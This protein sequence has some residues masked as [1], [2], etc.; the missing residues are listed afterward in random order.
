MSDFNILH[1]ETH[2]PCLLSREC[3]T[4]V[5]R[6]GNKAGLRPGRLGDLIRQNTGANA[7]GL[8]CH[9]TIAYDSDHPDLQPALCRGFYDKFGHLANYIRI[10]ERIGG[11]TEIDPPE[12]GEPKP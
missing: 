7:T 2:K 8:I 6:P 9:S 12:H 5:F 1:P 11:F 3:D 10:S 4:C